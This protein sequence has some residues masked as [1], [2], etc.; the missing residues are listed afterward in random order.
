MFD[1]QLLFQLLPRFFS[2]K[3]GSLRFPTPRRIMSGFMTITF[4][5]LL[6]IVNRSFML[7]DN[8]LFPG[9]RKITMRKAVFITGVPRSAT[10]YLHGAMAD[11]QQNF[12]CFRLYELIF[13]PSI[14]QKYF[15]AWII[16]IDRLAGRPLYRLSI[17]W[18]KIFLSRISRLHKTGITQPEEDEILLLFA[19]SSVFLTFLFPE[20]RS[21]ERH[22]FF[23]EEIDPAKRRKIMSFYKACLQ[24]H[25]YFHDP[26][27][28]KY[29]LSKNPSFV[30]KTLSLKETFPEARLLY[31]LRSPA[32][33][34]PSLINL[35]RN[36]YSLF[37]GNLEVNPLAA[38][39]KQMVIRWYAMADRALANEW[40]SN[41][42]VVPFQQI[43]RNPNET[44][45]AIYDFIGL[46]HP[47]LRLSVVT[48]KKEHASR[49][50]EYT[51]ADDHDV[52]VRELG[53]VF[54]GPHRDS[55]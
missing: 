27:E 20:I 10:T 17:L 12:T 55:I 8:L 13:A 22:L 52:I 35:N 40:I 50:P 21:A 41:S 4:L 54:D 51:V 34:I 47:H 44:I 49:S 14:I 29:F 53:F 6:T 11:D 48:G 46:P 7:I 43:T 25:V 3:K 23:D 9:F 15:L 33:T 39:T 16:K 30:S 31:M 36:L 32:Y 5:L 19:Y 2:L 18:D 24:R 26:T 45:A 1:F 28:Q 42:M 37:Y 38:E